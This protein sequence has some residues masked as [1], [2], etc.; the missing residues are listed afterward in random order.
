MLQKIS[1]SC[2]LNYFIRLPIAPFVAMGY[3]QTSCANRSGLVHCKVIIDHLWL[4]ESSRGSMIAKGVVL[5]HTTP[6]AIIEPRG[7]DAPQIVNNNFTVY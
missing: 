1:R 4:R 2:E 6:F 3:F 7:F 5:P